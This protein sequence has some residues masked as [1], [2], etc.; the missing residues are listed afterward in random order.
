MYMRRDGLAYISTAFIFTWAGSA[1]AAEGRTDPPSSASLFATASP[2]MILREAS[3]TV[4]TAQTLLEQN[5]TIAFA[6]QLRIY[7]QPTPVV[8]IAVPG[9]GTVPTPPRAR[10]RRSS[11]AFRPLI[12]DV[13]RR[14]AIDPDLIRSIA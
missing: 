7:D 14:Y 5:S 13:G 10:S 11:E 9:P 12:D 8:R 1:F 4:A 6:E 2:S 3:A